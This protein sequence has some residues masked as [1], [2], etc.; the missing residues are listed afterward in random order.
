MTFGEKIRELR[1]QAGLTQSELGSAV[2]VT[3]RT[4]RGWE[5]E[6]RFPKKQSTYALLAEVLGCRVS[7]LLADDADLQAS[8]RRSDNPADSERIELIKQQLAELF[9]GSLLS[10]E[11]KFSLITDIQMLYINSKSR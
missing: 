11:E 4:V 9:S 6:G 2:R 1:S 8:G 10:D 3:L 5:T 7:Y